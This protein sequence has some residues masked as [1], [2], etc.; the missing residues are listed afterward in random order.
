MYRR[1]FEGRHEANL[2]LAR[3]MKTEFR[4]E[5]LFYET[6][7]CGSVEDHAHLCSRTIRF[8]SSGHVLSSYRT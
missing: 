8:Q 1:L 6:K 3:H 4:E 2:S 5:Q 7:G